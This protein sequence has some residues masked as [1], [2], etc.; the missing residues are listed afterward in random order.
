MLLELAVYW[1]AAAILGV[2][3]ARLVI[4]GPPPPSLW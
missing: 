4:H 1:V 3:L 2:V